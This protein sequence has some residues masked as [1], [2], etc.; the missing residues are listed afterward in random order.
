MTSWACTQDNATFSMISKKIRSL[1]NACVQ[2]HFFFLLPQAMSQRGNVAAKAT[3]EK[4]VPAF[5]YRPEQRDCVYVMSCH[6][7]SLLAQCN[8]KWRLTD[9]LLESL[10]ANVK[11][12]TNTQRAAIKAA[13]WFITARVLKDQWIRAK[14]ERREFIGEKDYFQQSYGAGITTF[15]VVVFFFECMSINL[16]CVL[17][18]L[19]TIEATL[20]KKGKDNRHFL[21]RIF[22]LSH[23]DFTLRYF[24][25]QNVGPEIGLNRIWENLEFG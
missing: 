24:T 9:M 18:V 15:F 19:D 7:C 6:Q 14:Y 20:W 8:W 5:I 21:K 11:M 13:W 16:F 2:C 25:K 22:L 17:D 1:Y 4:C 12:G 3:Y 10:I 23:K